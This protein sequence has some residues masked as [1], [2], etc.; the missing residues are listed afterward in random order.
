M[1]KRSISPIVAVILL[2]VIT[3]GIS[4]FTY[5]YFSGLLNQLLIQTS[6]KIEYI[7]DVSLLSITNAIWY[8]Y[9]DGLVLELRF[10]EGYGN[11][12]Y[13]TSGNN[14]HGTL[15]NGPKWVD[16]I[17]GKALSFD[18]VNDYV[19]ARKT[20]TYRASQRDQST[21][22]VLFK[23][24]TLPPSGY[25]YKVLGSNTHDMSIFIRSDGQVGFRHQYNQYL[26]SGYAA[27]PN[28]R[29]FAA[30]SAKYLSLTQIEY[31]VFANGVMRKGVHTHNDLNRNNSYTGYY[32]GHNSIWMGVYFNG[33][34]DEVRIYNKALSDDIIKNLFY[35]IQLIIYN[36]S[37][38]PININGTYFSIGDCVFQL[39][40]NQ[41]FITYPE[42]KYII[43]PQEQI[44]LKVS[45]INC[46][47]ERDKEYEVCL[48]HDERRNCN[49]VLI[50]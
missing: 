20:W 11:I 7:S 19:E 38:K 34:I 48:L 33:T 2:I 12:T 8:D 46:H 18:G 24:N 22:I 16:G 30:A 14:N 36:P 42:N 31:V 40:Y 10:D 27:K 5:L 15:Y 37:T 45:H 17:L 29:V 9:R 6:E 50:S 43:Y 23:M 13:D 35:K 4:A 26:F 1:Y 32:I 3:V 39:I 25:Y 41:T 21:W 47:L 28:E 49:N 44:M